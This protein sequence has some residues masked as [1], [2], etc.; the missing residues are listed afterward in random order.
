MKT[1]ACCSALL[2]LALAAPAQAGTLTAYANDFDAPAT[3]AAGVNADVTGWTYA[4]DFA[5]ANSYGAW[6]GKRLFNFGSAG[7]ATVFT[8][9]NLPTHTGISASFVLGLL[10]SWDSSDGDDG[11]APDYLDIFIDGSQV[12]QLTYNNTSGTVKQLAGGTL[13]AEYDESFCCAGFPQ[14]VVDMSSASYLTFAHTASTFTL[15][16]AASGAGYTGGSDEEWG[17][18]GLRIDLTGTAVPEPGSWALMI[19]GFGLAGASLR[20]RAP[21]GSVTEG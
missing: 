3:T 18:D 6:D 12:A 11:L 17:L 7:T 8:L 1:L 20:R 5:T 13:L 4:V 9:S 19:A 2:I 10:G 16:I 15:S 14:T 21:M